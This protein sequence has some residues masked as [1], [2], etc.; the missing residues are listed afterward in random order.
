VPRA[1]AALLC[2]AALGF[3]AG[4]SA[5]ARRSAL[6]VFLAAR[7]PQLAG[8]RGMSLGIM[9]A[10]Q[11]RYSTAQLLL[12]ITQG[13]RVS[14]SSYATPGPPPL[15]LQRLGAG[16][17]VSGWESAR[18]RA[19]DAPQLLA[20]G[21]LAQQI[22]GG[23]GYAGIGSWAGAPSRA[24]TAGADA[25]AVAASHLDAL[26]AADRRG[27]IAAV[28]LGAGSTLL[29]R[30]AALRARKRLVVADLPAGAGGGLH[31]RCALHAP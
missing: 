5:A 7:E 3:P 11:G 30:I 20:P 28:S 25:G 16:A 17:I 4:A 12:D 22:R 24:G 8:V 26:L 23:A 2:A 21:L 10:A 9:S 14:T 19:E 18:R 29:A 31:P 1:A 15:S 27:R 6:V 13:A